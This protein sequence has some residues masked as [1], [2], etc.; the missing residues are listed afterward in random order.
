[1]I[2]TFLATGFENVDPEFLR[3]FV[4]TL[5]GAGVFAVTIKKLLFEKTTSVKIEGTIASTKYVD[6]KNDELK[7][8]VDEKS[9]EL[10]ESIGALLRAETFG[11]YQRHADRDREELKG[12]VETL[13]SELKQYSGDGYRSRRAMHKKV[14]AHSNALFFM[15]GQ[16]PHGGEIK[17]ILERADEGEGGA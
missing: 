8:S 11:I 12:V 9:K 17:R 7:Q 6:G 3:N 4:V 10:R 13:S 14:N 2:L 16:H 15:A 1:M 5:A